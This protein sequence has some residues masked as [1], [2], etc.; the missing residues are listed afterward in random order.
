MP[1]TS[2]LKPCPFCGGEV[3]FHDMIGDL[4][5]YIR[6]KNEDCILNEIQLFNVMEDEAIIMWNNR[7]TP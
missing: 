4:G 3:T 6:C 1:N 7:Y 5:T 2:E